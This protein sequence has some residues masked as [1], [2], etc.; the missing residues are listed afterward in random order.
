[1][2][3]VALKYANQR[4]LPP[5]EI[6]TMIF[7]TRPRLCVIVGVSELVDAEKFTVP[8]PPAMA[9]GP[10]RPTSWTNALIVA[11]ARSLRAIVPSAICV[12]VTA[13][14]AIW[15]VPTAPFLMF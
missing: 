13:P 10:V 3:V 4:A 11:V 6:G 12:V 15:L 8:V 2:V 1:M 9:I 5:L 7:G 14:V